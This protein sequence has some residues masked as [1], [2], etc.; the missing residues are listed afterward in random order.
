MNDEKCPYVLPDPY[1]DE[2]WYSMVARYHRHSGNLRQYTTGK[3]LFGPSSKNTYPLNPVITDKRMV[4]YLHRQGTD[5]T[6][7]EYAKNLTLDPFVLRFLPAKRKEEVFSALRGEQTVSNRPSLSALPDGKSYLRY[8]PECCKDDETKYGEMYW[9]RTHQIQTMSACP[10]HRCKILNSKITFRTA[11]YH[12]FAADETTCPVLKGEPSSPPE[13]LFSEYLQEFLLYPFSLQDK[14]SMAEIIDRLKDEEIIPPFGKQVVVSGAALKE[15]IT[16]KFGKNIAERCF[17][18]KALSVDLR[19]MLFTKTYYGTDGFALIAAYLEIP[20]NK[21]LCEPPDVN[22]G[23]NN[24]LIARVKEMANGGYKWSRALA[25]KKLGVSVALLESAT[26]E[27]G[28]EPFWYQNK[29]T[30]GM[31]TTPQF[32][33]KMYVTQEELDKINSRKREC[34]AGS[35]SEYLKYCVRLEMGEISK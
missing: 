20:T 3:E 34:G 16:L 22:T 8:C 23:G 5:E 10:I 30:K 25:A 17:P 12:L 21:V 28:I 14:T 24:D 33:A 15:R 9:H 19:R 26:A 2:L 4:E 7:E 27:A 6:L 18:L 32:Q 1:P 35:M 31:H 29:G 13:I 11:S